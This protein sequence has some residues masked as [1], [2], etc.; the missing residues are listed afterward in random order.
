MGTHNI[1]F[2]K[3]DIPGPMLIQ[4]TLAIKNDD[5]KYHQNESG[6]TKVVQTSKNIF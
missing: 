2:Q 4:L 1:C 6:K 5:K 3:K